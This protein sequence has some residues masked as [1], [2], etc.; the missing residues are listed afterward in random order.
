MMNKHVTFVLV[1]DISYYERYIPALGPLV[2][3][4]MPLL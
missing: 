2:D 4:T 3:I 1:M